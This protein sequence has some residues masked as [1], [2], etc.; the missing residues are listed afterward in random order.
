MS[1]KASESRAPAALASLSSFNLSTDISLPLDRRGT[2]RPV[3]KR[4]GR[5]DAAGYNT[6]VLILG[7]KRAISPQKSPAKVAI[8]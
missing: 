1:E 3:L 5:I 4:T 8:D 2:A 7:E 6:F